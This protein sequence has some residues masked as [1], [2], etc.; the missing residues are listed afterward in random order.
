[1][2]SPARPPIDE[3]SLTTG[4]DALLDAYSETVAG[5]VE[6]A[7]D[8][9]VAI[10]AQAAPGGRSGTGSGFLRCSTAVAG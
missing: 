6:A 5:T 7:R 1:L 4:D 10:S 8:A 3:T 9:V 2:H